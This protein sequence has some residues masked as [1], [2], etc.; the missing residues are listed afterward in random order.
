MWPEILYAVLGALKF[1]TTKTSNKQINYA[2]PRPK[3]RGDFLIGHVRSNVILEFPN[4]DLDYH[5]GPNFA[6]ELFRT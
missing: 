4:S 3:K 6:F 5:S 2:Q 1:N